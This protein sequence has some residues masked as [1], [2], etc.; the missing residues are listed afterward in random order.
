MNDLAISRLLGRAAANTARARLCLR[1]GNK[2]EARKHTDR[3]QRLL[4]LA[5]DA[6]LVGAASRFLN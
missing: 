3:A 1:N 2:A 5:A 4:L 6:R